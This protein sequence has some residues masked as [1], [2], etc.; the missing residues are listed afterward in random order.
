[1]PSNARTTRLVIVESPS[2]AKTIA[3]YLG[4]DYLVEASVGHIRDLP[5]NADEVPEEF[6]G[7]PWARLGVDVD[8]GFHALYV[9]S[10]SRK[11]QVA[12]LK[13]LAKEV[14]EIFL[15][16]DE[17]REGEA[18]AWH[19]I[20]TIKPKVPFKRMV[21]HEITKPA[22]QAAVANPRDID[23]SLVDAQ[24]A[25]RILDRL[26]GYEVSPVLWKKV[27]RGLSAGRVQS[28]A[29]R[30]VVERERQRMAFRSAEYW[31]ILAHLAVQGQVEGPRTFNATLIALNG[32]RIATGKDFEPTTGQLRPA[33][34]AVQLDG[35]GARGLAAR[36]ENRPFTVTRTEEKPYRR[37]PYAP[38][39]TSTLQQEAARKMRS[40]SQ[41]TMRT[42]QSLYEKG[43]ITY[44]RT[45]SVNLSET[46]VAAARRQIAELYGPGNVP[47]QPRKY[48]TK[49]KGA[50][51]AHE[52]IRPAGDNF[53][54]P[55]E[56]ANELSSDEFRLY[57]LIWRRTIASQMTDA[58]GNSISVRIRAT[59]AAGEE[60]DF[61]ASGKT[62]T[63]PGFLRAYVESSDDENAESDDAERRLPNL[64]KD[65][66]LSADA[67][68]AAGHHTSPPARYTEA[69]LVKALE[70]LGIGRPSTYS[71]IMQTIQDRGYVE[72]RG[73]AMIPSFLAFA[74]IGL[75]EGHYPRLVDYNF[76]AAMEG[77]LDDIAAG[78][79]TQLNF[80]SSFYFGSQETGADDDI[81]KAGGLKKMVT[82]NLSAIDAREVNS[83]PLFVDEENRRTVVRVGK[84]GP[85]LQRKAIDGGEDAPEDKASL[86]EG[87]AP[88]E[89]T[90]EKVEELFLA[91]NGDRV[92]GEDPVTGDEVTVKSGRFG[93][94]V[95]AGERK[96][97]LFK[98][99]S[100][101]T[102]TLEQAL[103]L[104]KLPRVVGK[105]AD[106]NEIVAR[107]G[108]FGPYISR[109]KDSR[110]L[111]S[112]SQLLTI[113][114]EEALALLAQPKTRQSRTAK[115]PLRELGEDPVSKKP[116][117]IKDGR[118]GS[119][120]TDG[121]FNATL[122]RDQTP[123]E[124]TLEEAV[125]M[126][127][128][129]R[130]KGPA[131]K[132]RAAAKKAPAKA[133]AAKQDGATPAKKAP[134]KRATAA[135]KTT[136][137]AKKTTAAKTTTAAKKAPAKKAAPR[138]ATTAAE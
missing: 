29:T 42:A 87:I 126:I 35:D 46:A 4:P 30:I 55:G 112:E 118:F 41:Q 6:K 73:Q 97:S 78:D 108:K 91:G 44:M 96:S 23:R 130:A 132:K 7:Q 100:P 134:A 9:I 33:S 45:D 50:Q 25:R 83:I 90:P 131:P 119:Y 63:D 94:Y 127:A 34:T 84:F 89:L 65:Q 93:P 58:V 120:V 68:N 15:A 67:L 99:Q 19:L 31:D 1:M 47:P 28:V 64:V 37:R 26:Y 27:M 101:Q 113:T 56:V 57:E 106:G 75:L 5:R 32:D 86:P 17:D 117:V 124:I 121:E 81:A 79:G 62:I 138:K 24:E 38:F 14:D 10:D 59:T 49:A 115:P 129:K 18:I 77:Q 125:Q 123:E 76:T 104:L 136:T 51:E 66:P 122:R 2:K 102:V 22:I 61:A 110:S 85:Y 92:L 69:S 116:L 13:R 105:D 72:K 103:D 114:L 135:K 53:R 39:I 133:A 36:L 82:E 107:N 20:E 48:T 8:N 109:E 95:S 70:E 40:S 60:A 74:V 11:Q 80:L 71:S 98:D 16:T 43:Y 12:K 52:A 111:A 3:G 54:T 21:F 88:D 128:D 137:A